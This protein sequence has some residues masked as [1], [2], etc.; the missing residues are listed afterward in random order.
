MHV[1]L[2]GSVSADRKD[3]DNNECQSDCSASQFHE[4]DKNY[5][6]KRGDIFLTLLQYINNLNE[7][8]NLF[9]LCEHHTVYFISNARINRRA[10]YDKVSCTK[11]HYN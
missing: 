8:R 2:D 5:G 3:K 1:I 11:L 6:S 9:S 10:N 7:A 4:R